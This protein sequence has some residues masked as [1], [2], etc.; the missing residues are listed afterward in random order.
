M[1][2]LKRS[3]T[4]PNAWL[5]KE[6]AAKLYPNLSTFIRDQG[7][8]IVEKIVLNRQNRLVIGRVDLAE[9]RCV[10]K[11]SALVYYRSIDVAFV[12]DFSGCLWPIEVGTEWLDD[13]DPDGSTILV[14]AA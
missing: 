9:R 1:R 10:K 2:H 4:A 6:A 11:H 12:I 14:K 13:P 8:G 7:C 5:L 3:W